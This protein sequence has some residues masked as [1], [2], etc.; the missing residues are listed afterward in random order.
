MSNGGNLLT[1]PGSHV[2]DN[3]SETHKHTLGT[4]SEP[5]P[6]IMFVSMI[7]FLLSTYVQSREFSSLLTKSAAGV[8]MAK[9]VSDKL[10]AYETAEALDILRKAQQT[11]GVVDPGL[12]AVLKQMTDNLDRYRPH[13]QRKEMLDYVFH[14][15]RNLLHSLRNALDC[16]PTEAATTWPEHVEVVAVVQQLADTLDKMR[17]I[18]IMYEEALERVRL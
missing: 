5:W 14:E 12:V 1:L 13:L 17:V 15:V 9:D 7:A 4:Y 2:F 11:A 18:L 16:L 3:F 6:V 10:V 8:Q